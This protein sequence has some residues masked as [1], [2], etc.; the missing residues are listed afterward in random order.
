MSSEI[1]IGCGN[2]DKLIWWKPTCGDLARLVRWRQNKALKVK[3]TP[4]GV[5]PEIP[6]W[7]C[8]QVRQDLESLTWMQ[9]GFILRDSCGFVWLTLLTF[10]HIFMVLRER[11]LKSRKDY[12]KRCSDWSRSSWVWLYPLPF[13]GW[14]TGSQEQA[15]ITAGLSLIPPGRHSPHS[16][17]TC[18]KHGCLSHQTGTL[19]GQGQLL[20]SSWDP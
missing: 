11:G 18:L 14:K 16:I 19:Q 15:D 12:V 4:L 2:L 5:G 8:Y 17:S 10:Y 9:G 6:V 7:K 20:L 3:A 13:Q 1:S